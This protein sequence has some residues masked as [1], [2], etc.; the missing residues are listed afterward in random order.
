M[1]D[2]QSYNMYISGTNYPIVLISTPNHTISTSI[3]HLVIVLSFQ[4]FAFLFSLQKSKMADI[5]S[6]KLYISETVYPIVLI[7]TPNHT[8]SMTIYLLVTPTH[9]LSNCRHIG[10]FFTHSRWRTFYLTRCISQVLFIQTF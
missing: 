9:F 8:V 7:P 2:I 10:F 3:Y 1:A 6:Y 5:Q 4:T